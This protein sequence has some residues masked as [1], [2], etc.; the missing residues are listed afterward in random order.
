MID[1]F[2]LLI[3]SILSFTLSSSLFKILIPQLY[4]LGL[5][6]K[7][8]ERKRHGKPIAN[9]GGVVIAFIIFILLMP[10]HYIYY[11][12][13]FEILIKL[14][15]IFLAI[16][17][18][19]LIDDINHI[20]PLIRLFI[21]LI[22]AT[23]TVLVFIPPQTLLTLHISKELEIAVLIVIFTGF[24]NIYNFLDGIDSISAIESIHLSLCMLILCYLNPDQIQYI[25]FVLTISS[26]VL[27]FSCSFLMFNWHPAKIFL[28]DVGSIGLG[29]LIGFCLMMIAISN[30]I[31]LAS[32]VIA[33]LYYLLDGGLT[34]II[35]LINK[36]KIW[37]PH[38]KHFFQKALQNGFSHNQVIGCI[39]FCNIQLM[40][41]SILALYYPIISLILAHIVVMSTFAV[42]TFY[43]KLAWN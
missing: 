13:S 3:L 16:S 20:N 30:L 28:G 6:D 29:F 38:L 27:G 34:I 18:I 22:C 1:S 32:V 4:K 25:S 43:K 12:E 40:I 19:S 23:F 41:L 2:Q 42:F 5:I 14:V 17:I 10:Y 15:L 36:E 31:L 39:I 26:M 37:Q 8:N 11:E 35:R 24:I 21:H 9:S 33:S 7:P